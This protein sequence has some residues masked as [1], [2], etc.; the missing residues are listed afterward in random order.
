MPRGTVTGKL[1][2]TVW[3]F[4]AASSWGALGVN[5]GVS[6]DDFG[7]LCGLLAQ[8][9]S[10][11]MTARETL[12]AAQQ[13]LA[14]TRQTLRATLD[15][16]SGEQRDLFLDTIGPIDEDR[17]KC[18]QPPL[19]VRPTCG[20]AQTLKQLEEVAENTT[21]QAL[22]ALFGLKGLDAAQTL[23]SMA[24][25]KKK[26]EA[27]EALMKAS[28]GNYMKANAADTENTPGK[29]IAVDMIFLCNNAYTSDS[30]NVC[31]KD[32]GTG[33]NCPCADDAS[34]AKIANA[35]Q[36]ESINFQGGSRTK[37]AQTTALNAW[38][39][40][41][42]LCRTR[43]DAVGHTSRDT[44]PGALHKA[45]SQVTHAW[46]KIGDK[47]NCL[48][49][50]SATQTDCDHTTAA[51]KQGCVCY[52]ATPKPAWLAQVNNAATNLKI[53]L[54]L[55]ERARQ[56]STV[57]L[58]LSTTG[59]HGTANKATEGRR[60]ADDE[61]DHDGQ[62]E[63]NTTQQDTRTHTNTPPAGTS[64]TK[65]GK[66]D[67]ARRKA[68]TEDSTGKER[69]AQDTTAAAAAWRAATIC[70]TMLAWSAQRT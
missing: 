53:A 30:A 20:A 42:K 10:A 55:A 61:H 40:A 54:R 2:L 13:E 15:T 46:H 4:L 3:C 51:N 68:A 26:A 33:A 57:L 12:A 11:A 60:Q 47:Q 70:H 67:A 7:R 28:D 48:G 23:D 27:F 63:S 39:K 25:D 9:A 34:H 31:G 37:A 41:L 59:Q 18:R 29:A 21:Q 69:R 8:T 58:A 6:K 65:L 43:S 49:D 5:V 38:D 56:Y 36:D 35:A 62:Q 45:T 32:S 64:T 50:R 14:G 24:P 66:E 1:A 17:T 19:S 16:L 52:G 22:E 44:T